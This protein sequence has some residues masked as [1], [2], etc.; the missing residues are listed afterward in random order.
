MSFLAVLIVIAFAAALYFAI[1]IATGAIDRSALRSEQRRLQASYHPDRF[2][3]AGDRDRRPVVGDRGEVH[4]QLGPLGL[5]PQFHP[6]EH[7]RRAVS[8]GDHHR[9]TA[10]TRSPA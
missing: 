7:A 5:Q 10:T 4:L 3:N 6:P 9:T 8:S 1:V 2:V